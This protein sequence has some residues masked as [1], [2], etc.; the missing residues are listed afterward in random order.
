MMLRRAA[1]RVV[2]RTT[3]TRKAAE[4]DDG[5]RPRR[6][7]SPRR[8]GTCGPPS[9]TPKSAARSESD[10][11]ADCLEVVHARLQG[12]ELGIGDPIRESGPALVEEDQA[13]ERSQPFE[14]ARQRR[15]LPGRLDMGDPAGHPDQVARAVADDLIGDRDAIGGSRVARLRITRPVSCRRVAGARAVGPRVARS[16][17]AEGFGG[18]A[19]PRRAVDLRVDA[20]RKLSVGVRA[21]QPLDRVQRSE[22]TLTESGS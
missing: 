18:V 8:A 15:L 6:D 14:E 21:S 10:G 9:E 19:D 11:I 20:E 1:P 3:A 2:G 5:A 13:G 16:P 7:T 22:V 17:A 12:R 4:Q